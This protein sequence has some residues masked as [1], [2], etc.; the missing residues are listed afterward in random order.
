MI[1][2]PAV[3]E[4]MVWTSPSIRGNR[5]LRSVGRIV[6]LRH[7]SQTVTLAPPEQAVD[8]PQSGD[9]AKYGV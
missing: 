2:Y 5:N 8:V 7:P 9:W 4:S 1:L 3:I 6:F